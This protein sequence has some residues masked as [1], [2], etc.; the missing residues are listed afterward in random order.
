MSSGEHLDVTAPV[1]LGQ[2]LLLQPIDSCPVEDAAHLC[3]VT[4]RVHVMAAHV[5]RHPSESSRI[6]KR[7]GQ[8]FG[9]PEIPQDSRELAQREERL[10]EVETKVDRA[11]DLL[12]R[13]GQWVQG[14]QCLLE[15]AH[16]RAC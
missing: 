7:S 13:V 11:L 14:R 9:F 10:T 3:D 6:V 1:S 15:P 5:G 16:R 2:A 12:A 8:R 4:A